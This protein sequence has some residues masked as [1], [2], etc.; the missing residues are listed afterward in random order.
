MFATIK[1][2]R[3]NL[4]KESPKRQD[5]ENL[6]RKEIQIK[7]VKKKKDKKVKKKKLH[8][9]CFFKFKLIML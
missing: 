1:R 2:P 6:Q 8:S 5:N 7:I 3:I 9:D 4:Q